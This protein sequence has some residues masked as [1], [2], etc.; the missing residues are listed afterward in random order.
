M[1]IPVVVFFAIF[2]YAPMYGIIIAFKNYKITEGI[3]HSPWVGFQHFEDIFRTFT[4]VRAL[5]NTIIISLLKLMFGF[6]V[7][8]TLALFL[9][10]LRN[11]KF[12]RVLQTVSYLP[13]FLSW[14]ILSGLFI[15]FLSP[16]TGPVNYVISLFNIE[17]IYFLGDVKWFRFTLVITD[18]WKEM[19]WG[20]VIFL[21]TIAGIN[22]ELYEAS[23]CDGASRFQQAFFITLPQLAPTIT[24]LLL[25]N[26]GKILNVGFDQVF[27]LYN[28]AV[29]ETGDIIDT[30]VYRRGLTQMDYSAATAVGLFKNG[31]GFIL[32]IIMN[33]ITKRIN[34]Y[35][36]W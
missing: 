21:A 4:F 2:C 19:G 28:A 34:E 26:I 3:L 24:I 10:E 23:R 29:Y 33:S 1:F 16:T 18:I 22:P 11:M 35:G 7:P 8:I 20:S 17:P 27:N 5:K 32:I 25:L 9:N 14:V 30:Y 31:I 36:I 12:K 6:P 15:F 13:H